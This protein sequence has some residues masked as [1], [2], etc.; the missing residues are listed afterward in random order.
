[1]VEHK[2]F[3]QNWSNPLILALASLMLIQNGCQIVTTAAYIIYGNEEKPPCKVKMTGRVAVLCWTD[4]SLTYTDSDNANMVGSELSKK[5]AL[6]LGGKKK[7]KLT[8]VPQQEVLNR[9]DNY[10]DNITGEED[11][12]AIAKDLEADYLIGV[13]LMSFE[14]QEGIGVYQ[15]KATYA[16]TLIDGKK[17]EVVYDRQ[18]IPQYVYP[19]NRTVSSDSV[20]G[21]QFRREYISKLAEHIGWEFY[22]HDRHDIDI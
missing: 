17:G 3:H 4:P 22:P 9:L 15:G 18:V 21:A 14:Y 7:D 2:K 1:M 13:Y 6:K 8:M 16:V 5:I 20:N 10:P 11:L 12:I 19:P